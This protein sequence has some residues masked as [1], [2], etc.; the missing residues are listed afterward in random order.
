MIKIKDG[1]QLKYID[2]FNEN[3]S[4]AYKIEYQ[5]DKVI[6]QLDCGNVLGQRRVC[7]VKLKDFTYK[8]LVELTDKEYEK[9][10]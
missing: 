4:W 2:F 9:I 3:T 1:K 10:K 5:K 7:V 6:V 8:L